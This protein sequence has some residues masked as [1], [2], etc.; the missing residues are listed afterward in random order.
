MRQKSSP[1]S[2]P[3]ETSTLHSRTSELT[4][5]VQSACPARSRLT[6]A[7]DGEKYKAPLV[8]LRELI[9]RTHRWE[10][11][12]SDGKLDGRLTE[13]CALVTTGVRGHTLLGTTGVRGRTRLPARTKVIGGPGAGKS[14]RL[15][16]ELSEAVFVTN[17]AFFQPVRT[18]SFLGTLLRPLER[19]APFQSAS[20]S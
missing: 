17:A 14:K 19:E 4:D 1:P 10:K 2:S 15:A 9:A 12:Q 7:P 20:Q 3:G 13:A 11:Q 5:L 8:E 18:V 6:P 16:H